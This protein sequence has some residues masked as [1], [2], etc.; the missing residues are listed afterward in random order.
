VECYTNVDGVLTADP[1]L[2]PDAFALLSLSYDE[3]LHLAS[4][5]DHPT[6]PL[7]PRLLLPLA[8]RNISLRIRNLHAPEAVGTLI[9]AAPS[10]SFTTALALH[11]EV[12]LVTVKGR[13]RGDVPKTLSM[14][15]RLVTRTGITPLMLHLTNSY[16]CSFLIETRAAEV[17]V[18]TLQG[19]LERWE[20]RCQTDLAACLCLGSALT[21]NPLNL[22]Y[23]VVALADERI[24][25]LSQGCSEQGLIVVVK[26]EDGPRALRRLHRDFVTPLA[27]S[28]RPVLE[29][30]PVASV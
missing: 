11:R 10:P 27:P 20:V 7:Q 29:V 19:S 22:A 21:R 16:A 3:A 15:L 24:P 6:G 26:V 9:S 28:G 1:Q 4:F 23:A 13:T 8:A 17:V 30:R 5:G 12:A 25:V 18:R 2:V 14:L